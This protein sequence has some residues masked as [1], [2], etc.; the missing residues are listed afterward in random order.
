MVLGLY[1]AYKIGKRASRRS[2]RRYNS[3]SSDGAELVIALFY[4]TYL[5]LKATYYVSLYVI[6][7]IRFTFKVMKIWS[8]S[9]QI[10]I[11]SFKKNL[12]KEGI[13]KNNYDE[14]VKRVLQKE[15]VGT[16]VVKNS[17][18]VVSLLWENIEANS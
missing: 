1:A 10:F 11:T 2:R 17:T 5:A 7:A 4:L 18:P 15:I 16:P 14:D 6:K 12:Y 13:L 3:S 8:L 9:C